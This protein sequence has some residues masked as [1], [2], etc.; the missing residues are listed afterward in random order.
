MLWY[1]NW[2]FSIIFTSYEDWAFEFAFSLHFGFCF[3]QFYFR[4]RHVDEVRCG[5]KRYICDILICCPLD[6]WGNTFEHWA[7]SLS[8]PYLFVPIIPNRT[9]Q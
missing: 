8:S 3:V 4:R 1:K 9:T 2:L 7:S 5:F 6:R